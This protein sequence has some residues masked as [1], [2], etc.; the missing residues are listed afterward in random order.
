[1]ASTFTGLKLQGHVGHFGTAAAT[2]IDG[3]LELPDGRVKIYFVIV[4][5]Y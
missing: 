3:Y 5:M 4:G 1:M 2:D